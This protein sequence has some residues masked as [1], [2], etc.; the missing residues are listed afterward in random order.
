MQINEQNFDQEVIK[1]DLPVLVDFFATWCGPCQMLTP[2]I[3]E[4]DKEYHGR[5]KI[6]KIDIDDNQ[7][8]ASQYQ[9]MSV[10]S[11]ILFKNGSVAERL[12]GLQPKKVL[13]DKLDKLIS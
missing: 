2:T 4:L 13:A 12:V 7:N 3:E 6:I 9:V 8:L 5:A 1:S 11:L 10:P